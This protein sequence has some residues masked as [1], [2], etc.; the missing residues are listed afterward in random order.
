[1]A[2]DTVISL[3]TTKILQTG[4]GRGGG[5]G[6]VFRSQLFGGADNAAIKKT[7]KDD[8]HDDNHSGLQSHK[9]DGSTHQSGFFFHSTQQQRGDTAL[10]K[11]GSHSSLRVGRQH[12]HGWT[13]GGTGEGA[14]EREVAG[15]G[16]SALAGRS[17]VRGRGKAKVS[18]A[19]RPCPP[20]P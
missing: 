3:I 18:P 16:E 15:A 12:R 14:G 4:K 2:S 8:D 10:H 11:S 9:Y 17:Q 20:G 1:M 13:K 7:M 5:A 19:P 6:S